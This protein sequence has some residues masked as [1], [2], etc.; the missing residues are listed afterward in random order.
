MAEDQA[1]RAGA[2]GNHRPA[3]S[4]RGGEFCPFLNRQP[5]HHALH[6]RGGGRRAYATE[7]FRGP[8]SVGSCDARGEPASTRLHPW[9]GGGA[10]AFLGD[11]A[12]PGPP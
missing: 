10:D 7:T 2:P 11:S 1:V 6:L 9:G 8:W 3:P 12:H 5:G 4:A